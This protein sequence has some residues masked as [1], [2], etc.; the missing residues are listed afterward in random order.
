MHVQIALLEQMY[1]AG[2]MRS[3]QNQNQNQTEAAGH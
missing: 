1:M 3:H 2:C